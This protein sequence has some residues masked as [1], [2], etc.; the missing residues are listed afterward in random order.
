MLKSGV[1]TFRVNDFRIDEAKIYCSFSM[2]QSA[3]QASDT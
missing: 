2:K 3:M 1:A